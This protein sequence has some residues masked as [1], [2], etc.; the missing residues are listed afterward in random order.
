MDV[1]SAPTTV[2]QQLV[3]VR[4]FTGVMS[5]LLSAFTAAI[6]L[7]V[8][9]TFSINAAQDLA[10]AHTRVI[11]NK[12]KV[13]IETFLDRPILFLNAWQH[14]VEQ[15]NETLP[16][17]TPNYDTLGWYEPW[18]E[19]AVGPLGASDF[20]FQF[21]I[22]SFNDGNGVSCIPLANAQFRCQMYHWGNRNASNS[23]QTSTVIATDYFQANHS[24]VQRTS[25]PTGYDPRTRGWYILGKT[26][27]GV[28][29]W[30]TPL[31]SA[32][33]TLLCISLS[34]GLYNSSGYFLGVGSIFLNLDAM[35]ELLKQLLSIPNV[36]SFLIDNDN[37]LL[38]T[39]H[40]LPTSTTTSIV[41]GSIGSLPS[42]CLL[43]AN[44]ATLS[45]MMCREGVLSY[46]YGPLREQERCIFSLLLC[47]SRPHRNKEGNRDGLAVCNVSP[48][49]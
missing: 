28:M 33:P 5:V 31:L 43:S 37:L 14:S 11:A 30:G 35:G 39:T 4:T 16:K 6:L 21:S 10:S 34:T 25:S 42:N 44:G 3:S 29:R 49:G 15:S 47:G 32:V 18:I 17:D 22:L 23:S 40:N 41:T 27:P 38:E 13:E 8:T 9:F 36:V 24:V 45:I 7:A 12:A 2:F 26:P 48:R 46:G 1:A 20:S 19:R